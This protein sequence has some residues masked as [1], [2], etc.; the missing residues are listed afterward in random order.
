M[1]VC[2][3]DGEDKKRWDSFVDSNYGS[4]FHYFNCLFIISIGSSLWSQCGQVIVWV[5]DNK[6]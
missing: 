1:N 4:F 2:I 6:W 5:I 3:A